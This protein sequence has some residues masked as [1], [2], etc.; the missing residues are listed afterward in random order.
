[1]MI[2]E[3][4][5]AATCHD[6]CSRHDKTKSN[7]LRGG[8]RRITVGLITLRLCTHMSILP[9]QQYFQTRFSS[10]RMSQWLAWSFSRES[11]QYYFIKR[12]SYQHWRG[13]SALSASQSS[14]NQDGTAN[15]KL[16]QMLFVVRKVQ[17]IFRHKYL[18]PLAVKND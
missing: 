18:H 13:E 3:R 6:P 1:M 10:L 5:A 15:I 14:E 4:G 11:H 12:M 7:R 17:A 16:D 9:T 8:I 2:L